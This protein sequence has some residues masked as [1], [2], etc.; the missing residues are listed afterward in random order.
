MLWWCNALLL[1]TSWKKSLICKWRDTFPPL[2][3]CNYNRRVGIFLER[4]VSV[5]TMKLM[6]D[7]AVEPDH[8]YVFNKTVTCLLDRNIISVSFHRQHIPFTFFKQPSCTEN[9]FQASASQKV[10]ILLSTHYSPSCVS[11]TLVWWWFLCLCAS[12]ILRWIFLFLCETSGHELIHRGTG[13]NLLLLT[14][15]PL[16]ASVL[17]PDLHLE[18]KNHFSLISVVHSLLAITV[19]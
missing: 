19:V 13:M 18:W 10:P 11:D 17:E 16:H 5:I 14:V 3:D 4:L 8:I 9:P 6:L 15:S 2:T 7:Q 12:V 1:V